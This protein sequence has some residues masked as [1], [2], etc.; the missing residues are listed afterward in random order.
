[1]G[2]IIVL[3]I[4][5]LIVVGVIFY[6][7][8][9]DIS[10]GE[11]VESVKA[12][13]EDAAT[14]AKVKTA[15]ALSE[16]VSAY[17]VSVD[18]EGGVVTLSGQVPTEET[19]TLA[20]AIADGTTGVEGVRNDLT[21]DPLTKPDPELQQLSNRV[22][23]LEIRASIN[24]QL[25]QEPGMAAGGI[26]VVVDQ[27]RVTLGGNVDTPAQKRLAEQIAWSVEG[28]RS[29]QNNLNV[30]NPQEDSNS[31]DEKL[32]RQVEF[33]LYSS[34]AFELDHIE[35]I[36]SGT[37]VSLNGRVRSRAEMILAE[38]I[39]EGVDGVDRVVNSLHTAA[40]APGER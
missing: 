40:E 13:S 16:R 39:A 28:V 5:L 18:T 27:E 24:E 2:R 14:T 22:A 31:A 17:D 21:V 1:M 25:L 32:A 29:V 11:A 37:T 35:V 38:R 15:F 6:F 34:R 36:V 23:D 8:R 19:K 3:L 12:T 30:K 26:Q 20:G 7:Q 10:F 4:L 9:S 33:E